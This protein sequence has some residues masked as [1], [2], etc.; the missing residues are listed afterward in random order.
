MRSP[1][2]Q[3]SLDE[4]SS[5]V[6]EAKLKHAWR[7]KIGYQLRKQIIVDFVEF[8]DLDQDIGRVAHDICHQ[9]SLA[10]FRPAKPKYYLEEKSRGLCRQ[11]TLAQ[12]I[13]LLVLQCLSQS[14]NKDIRA[15][16]PTDRSFFEPGAH[17]FAGNLLFS[18]DDYGSVA[19]WK[20]FQE[21]IFEFSKERNYIVIADVAN[22]Y[23]FINFR[24]LRN[25]IASLCTV[26]EST[27]DFLLHILN[28]IA[29][30][31]DFMPRT[32]VGL[33]QMEIEAPR[34]LANAMLFELD[35]VA[36]EA[37]LGDYARFMDD[38][39]VG[40]DT[41]IEAKRVIRDIDLTLQSR[42]LRLNASKTKIL[43]V[44]TGE[45]AEYYCIKE[46]KF[47]DYCSKY[48][49]D[50]TSPATKATVRK[51]ISKAYVLWRGAPLGDPISNDSRFFFGQGEK[52]FKRVAKL[53]HY[54][55]HTINGEDL[56]WLIRNRPSLRANCFSALSKHDLPNN[57]FYR[58][59]DMFVIGT[60]VDDTSLVRMANFCVHARFR[61]NQKF[62]REIRKLIKYFCDRNDYLSIYS[63]LLLASKFLPPE[64]ILEIVIRTKA[65]WHNDYWLGRSVGGLAPRMFT[66]TQSWRRFYNLTQS[67]RNRDLDSV[68][69]F[70]DKLR[71]DI[72]SVRRVYHYAK[73]PNPAY[74]QGIFHPKA[75]IIL[76]ISCN[77]QAIPHLRTIKKSHGA[78]KSD[79]YYRSWGI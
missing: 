57:Y 70:H 59:V 11:M 69:M 60:F 17:K 27:L 22:F 75:L 40:V 1:K 45:A 10:Q 12:P 37:S 42:Q 33:P 67:V 9:I 47:L 46:N 26:Q 56:V 24:H 20:R 64:K 55:N 65:H 19:S 77:S 39:D 50:A 13:D 51:A 76:S 71:N 21:A 8:K 52:I 36:V 78:L 32:E 79:A 25:I 68:I 30:T 62:E 14:L 63:C 35:K 18:Y 6:N 72:A 31:P 15:Q 74:P 2:F 43:I 48:L 28:E 3:F 54:M 41:I 38:I 44:R 4:I 61:R 16:Q 7:K 49:Q 53:T 23:D 66:D 29:W 58:L 73:S 34:V 5:C